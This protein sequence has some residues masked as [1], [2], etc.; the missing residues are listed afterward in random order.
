MPDNEELKRRLRNVI[1]GQAEDPP[2]SPA[3][4]APEEQPAPVQNQ[5]TAQI[6]DKSAELQAALDAREADF[7]RL[8]ARVDQQDVE[9][10]ALRKA[11]EERAKMPSAKEL[12]ELDQGE[13]ILKVVAAMRAAQDA[14]FQAFADDLNRNVAQPLKETVGR[15]TLQQ[16]RDI[17]RSAYPQVDMNRYG[18]AFDEK[19]KAYPDLSPVEVLKLV[20]DPRDLSGTR[21]P[22]TPAPAGAAHMEVGRSAHAGQSASNTGRNANQV[23]TTDY[24]QAA[25]KAEDEGNAQLAKQLRQEG[26]KARLVNQ[27]VLTPGG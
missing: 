6:P 3:Q 2:E 15:V 25:A 12:N 9:A 8:Q 18:Q 23:T 27:G 21:E 26:L 14:K 19:A 4:P 7:A 1:P 13:A 22:R 11:L 5:D 20:A 16:K 24:L 17:A 10:A